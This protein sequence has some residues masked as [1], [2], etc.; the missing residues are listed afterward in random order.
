MRLRLL[1]TIEGN[2][3]RWLLNH[4]ETIFPFLFRSKTIYESLPSFLWETRPDDSHQTSMV[5]LL[6]K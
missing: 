4:S 2:E 1:V 3:K 5:R 6:E